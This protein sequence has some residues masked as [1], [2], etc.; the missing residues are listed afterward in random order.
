MSDVLEVLAGFQTAPYSHI[1]PSLDRASISTVDL[2][3]IKPQDIA[4]RAQVPPAEVAKLSEAI[5]QALQKDNEQQRVK[6]SLLDFSADTELPP[7]I[8]TLDVEI[9]GALD[10]GIKPGYLTEFTGERFVKIRFGLVL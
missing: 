8:S 6:A 5:V 3:T 10:G 7:K 4:K 9:D 2:I 1:L